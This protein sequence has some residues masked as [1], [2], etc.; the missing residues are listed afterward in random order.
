MLNYLTT[1]YLFALLQLKRSLRDPL[2]T[3]I[4]VLLPIVLLVAFGSFLARPNNVSLR[5]VIINHSETDFAGEFE[6]ALRDTDLFRLPEEPVSLEVA[7]ERMSKS[8][9]DTIIELPA[10]FGAANAQ[11][12][13]TGSVRVYYDGTATQ[14]GSIT[15]SIMNG[16]VDSFNQRLIGVD[17]PL[18]IEPTPLSVNR[19]SAI[20]WL[21]SA[22]TGMALLMVGV[23]GVGSTIPADKKANI[24]R[25]LHATPIRASQVNLGT[26]L[27]FGVIGLVTAGL[28]TAVSVLFF[29]MT[30]HGDWLTLILF[31]QAG[32]VLML[33]IGLA[34]AGLA[35]SS[36]QADVLG[37]IVFLSSMALGGIWIPFALMPAWM[38]NISS[39]IPLSPVITGL[40]MIVS[41]G[42]GLTDLGA[43][44]GVI[45][46][47]IVAVYLIGFKT[48]RWE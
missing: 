38:Q 16:I 25:R 36:S 4:I 7:K 8:E 34:I 26:M 29:D 23:F 33:G 15:S 5:A 31:L 17:M 48:F 12:V 45:G 28:M 10:D 37:Q 35:K 13:P 3:L 19:E 44:L 22:F 9:L 27:A 1:V 14:T 43:P 46:G 24:L 39:F 11:G 6:Q 20:D 2:T 40:G 41:D 47:W 42:A 30:I 21:Y 18:Q 32:L